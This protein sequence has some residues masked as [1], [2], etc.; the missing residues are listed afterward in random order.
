MQ[1]FLD[2][3]LPPA[4][5]QPLNAIEILQKKTLNILIYGILVVSLLMRII[6]LA[7]GDPGRPELYQ[8]FI[9][10]V[11]GLLLILLLE[12]Y[13][14]F[15][16]VSL[17]FDLFVIGTILLS[18]NELQI[19]QGE[20]LPFFIIP[21]AL[22]GLLIRPWAG[23]VAAG[24]VSGWVSFEVVRLG[25]GIPNIPTF[26]LFFITAL[27][28]HQSTSGL[29]Q[30]MEQEHKKSR[31]LRES[32]ELYHRLID[33]L[34]VGVLIHQEGKITLANSAC[35]KLAGAAQEEQLVGM[36]V[37][38]F[39]HPD[40]QSAAQERMG[41]VNAEGKT[42]EPMEEK[43]LRLDGST[44]YAESSATPF[45]YNGKPAILG[46]VNDI[47]ERMRF[48]E[49]IALKNE[50]IQEMSRR[51]MEVQERERR[52]LA[53]EL[54]DDLGQSLTSLK[55]LLELSSR[56]HAS[57]N[58]QRHMAEARELVAELMD[59]VRNLSL[60]LRPAV[61][62]DFGLLEAL[63]WLY[64]RFQTQMGIRVQ[65]HYDPDLPQR[66]EA[67]IETAAFRIIQEAL[68]NIVRHASVNEAEVSIS[69]KKGLIIEV[70]DHGAG[71]DIN[72][73]MQDTTGSPGISGMQERARLL[74]GS[75]QILS[76]PGSGTRVIA[77]IPLT[78]SGS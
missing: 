39:V 65:C 66:F 34:P 16:L 41:Q 52:L 30:A 3:V 60:E 57:T 49:S 37:L 43:F 2:R 67:H 11:A 73:T 21:I 76:W 4:R 20:T 19:I 28:I 50:R 69:A 7:L 63:R 74:G 31:L 77:H 18:D 14:P 32:E 64:D 36:R 78:R 62:D 9:A 71:F 51:L 22:A 29:E 35:V 1:R 42:I 17:A 13:V 12:R 48:N 8:G 24:L 46:V 56:A 10:A 6:L 40:F 44:F 47:T 59:K 45:F 25:L 23:Y 70:T 72:Q 75:L 54:H 5:K 58:R 15:P 33:V 27:V 38:D 61:L 68:T 55:L 26:G 53:S